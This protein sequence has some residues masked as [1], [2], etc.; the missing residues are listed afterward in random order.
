MRS[1]GGSSTTGHGR[2]YSLR[3]RGKT[4]SAFAHL[5]HLAAVVTVVAANVPKHLRGPHGDTHKDADK[6]GEIVF[7]PTLGTLWYCSIRTNEL[8]PGLPV[9]PF[10][11]A[12]A[13]ACGMGQ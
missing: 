4:N 6:I 13:T 2:S 9:C 5:E 8:P 1:I 3:R 11:T 12:T 10:I 7:L